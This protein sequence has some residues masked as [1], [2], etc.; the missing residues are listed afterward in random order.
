MKCKRS[1]LTGRLSREGPGTSLAGP[2]PSL[3][4]F[5]CRFE[6]KNLSL[7]LLRL[8]TTIDRLSI[9]TLICQLFYSLTW[10]AS[11][12][13]FRFQLWSIPVNFPGTVKVARLSCFHRRATSSTVL[14]YGNCSF[15]NRHGQTTTEVKHGLSRSVF[16]RTY[17][18]LGVTR[19]N[20]MKEQVINL[21]IQ[22]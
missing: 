18:G 11:Q 3:C 5:L 1:L 7:I 6:S 16:E 4:S 14:H 8:C 15:E 22:T 12:L 2:S 17:G 13:L 20:K 9:L 19:K 21:I 10:H